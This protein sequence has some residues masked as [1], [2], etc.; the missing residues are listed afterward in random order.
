[1]TTS[2]VTHAKPLARQAHEFYGVGEAAAYLNI[3]RTTMS[4]IYSGLVASGQVRRRHDLL[5]GRRVMIPRE[6]L[7]RIKGGQLDV[8]SLAVDS[9]RKSA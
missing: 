2:V 5:D 9:Q 3:S 4:R 8:E 6:L 1:M 7:D